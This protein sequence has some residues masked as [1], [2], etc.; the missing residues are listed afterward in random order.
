MIHSKGC[1]YLSQASWESLHYI[2]L[3]NILYR[4]EENNISEKGCSYLSK[5]TW[6]F[7]ERIYLSTHLYTKAAI[8]LEKK[9]A[10][11]YQK[12]IGSHYL[13]LTF[14]VIFSCR[15]EQRQ[16]KRMLILSKSTIL[17]IGKCMGE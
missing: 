11:I 14:V 13:F 12:E 6:P 15:K 7:L 3:S 4:T 5:T 17:A 10:R 2:G 16:L 8:L 1:K 9:D